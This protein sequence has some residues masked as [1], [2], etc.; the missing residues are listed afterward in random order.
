MTTTASKSKSAKAVFTPSVN[1]VRDAD[2]SLNYIPTPNATQ[3]YNQLINDYQTGIRSFN[4]V[5]AYGTGK[6]AF[7]WAFEKNINQKHAYFSSGNSAFRHV[8][9]FTFLSLIGEYN[10]VIRSFAKSP[11]INLK[12][13]LR[14]E[15]VI[16]NLDRYYKS[17]HK[18]GKGLVILIDEF[19]KFLEFAAKNNPEEELYFI[20]LLAEYVND[21]S[22]NIFFITTLHQDFHGYS[23]E[24]T[25]TQQYE[26]DKV[27]GRLKEITFNE[28]VEQ[29]LFLA[30][31][32]LRELNLGEKDKNFT[33]LFKAIETARAFPLRDYFNEN[34]A[35]KLL[36][37]DILSA[38]VLTLSLQ[39][40]GQNERSLFSFIESNDQF[41]LKDFNQRKNPYYNLG[42]IYDYLIHNYYS[43]LTSRYNPHHRQWAA[44]RTAIEKAEGLIEENV[45]DAVKL[46]KSIGLLNIFSLA[47]TRLNSNFLEEYGKYSLGIKDPNKLVKSLEGFKII[48]FV[49]HTGKYILSEGLDFD[50]ELAIDEAGNL[51]EKVTTV[52]HHL[53]AYF[54][55][56]YLSAR[57]AYYEKGTPRFFAY[58]L[59]ESPAKLSPE[60]EIDGFVNLIF[61]DSIKEKEIKE[62]SGNC[63]D[64]VLYGWYR[65][66]QDIANS[67][68]EIE[69]IKKV[70]ELHLDDQVAVKE[71]D[72][73]KQHQIRLLNHYVMGNMFAK[74]SPVQWYFQGEKVNIPDQR[75]FNRF[76]SEICNEVYTKTPVYKNE[77]V[78]KTKLSGVIATARKNFLAALTNNWYEADLAFEDTKFPPEKTI[79]LSLLKDTGI[80]QKA[81]DG[82]ILDAPTNKEA[83]FSLLWKECTDFLLSTRNGKRDL[84]QL[85]DKLL[86][87]PFK[88]K[89]GFIDF[90]LPVFLFSKRD[91]F[92]L[93]HDEVYIPYL[94]QETLELVSKDPKEYEIKAFDIEGVKLDLFNS[95]RTFLNQS[96]HETLTSTGFIETIRPFLTFYRQ[97][98]EYAKQTKKLSKKTTALRLAIEKAKDPEETFFD[99][100]PE[101]LGYNVLQLRKD[102]KVLA[103]YVNQLQDS[104]RE[105]RTCY[106]GLVNKVEVFI[107]QEIVGS[108]GSYPLYKNELQNRFKKIKKHLLL[109]YQRT[110]YDRLNSEIDDNKAWLNS[111]AQA[112]IGKPLETIS[113]E[114]EKVFYDK[115]KDI[116]HE[117]DNLCEISKSGFD[118][119]KEIAFKFEI[120]S[121]VEGLK[122]NLVRLP[123]SKN[124]ELIQLQSVVKAKLS[125]DRQLNIAT[126]AK[127]L[128]ELLNNGK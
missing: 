81:K 128:E 30:S 19:G 38:A 98:P 93:F 32:R 113:D 103:E 63:E 79:Y 65:N 75:T 88:L 41:G 114:E 21:S 61:S 74:N 69:K 77:M 13:N 87:K 115:F 56:P 83:K 36:P 104:I 57:A 106:D 76:L 67:L 55:F 60:G 7:L 120:T 64:A 84:E 110:F 11:E 86:A 53:N 73:I 22:K 15:E 43:F 99:R 17:L 127:L 37:F 78:N 97:L 2:V 92:A 101:A 90:W 126:L 50:I 29:L 70:R 6:S 89:Q 116:I 107:Q 122:K 33:K 91:D 54:D 51:V 111:I 48:R 44:I 59:S 108:L 34:F 40:Y 10:S 62:A 95:Y 8:K 80:H 109:P 23:R 16:L 124:K 39:K 58:H 85:T 26:W 5:G 82:F 4:L 9:G 12:N 68:F 25:K 46:V 94:T 125:D 1:I 27:K 20:Q 117:L 119:N 52:V 28:P 118:E 123:K 72:I 49:R 112:C 35:S 42:C 100:F 18:A 96:H 105:I 45:S 66:T 3:V 121:F 47:T 24:L 31:E 102:K 14:A 71:L